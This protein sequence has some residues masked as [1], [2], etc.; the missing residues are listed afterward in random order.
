[1]AVPLGNERLASEGQPYK[2]KDADTD[3]S[4]E[5]LRKG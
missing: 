1:M 4:V 3:G 2:G 5:K